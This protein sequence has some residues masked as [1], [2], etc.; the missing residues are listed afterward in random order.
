MRTNSNSKQREKN[1]R[2]KEIPKSLSMALA[3]CRT[4][5]FFQ[6]LIIFISALFSI[7]MVL[8]DC[9]A[10]PFFCKKKINKLS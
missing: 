3:N 6:I 9:G 7:L 1:K 10:S 5:M 4:D 8:S 2:K